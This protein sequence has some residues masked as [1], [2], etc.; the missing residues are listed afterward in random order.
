MSRVSFQVYSVEC[1]MSKCAVEY[2]IA[3]VMLSIPSHVCYREYIEC[4]VVCPDSFHIDMMSCRVAC[5]AS[6]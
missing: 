3:S 2:L 4:C 1:V 6:C 5:L